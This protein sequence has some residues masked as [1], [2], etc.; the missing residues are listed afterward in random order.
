MDSKIETIFLMSNIIVYEAPQT[1]RINT[2]PAFGS[3]VL[4]GLYR[5]WYRIFHVTTVYANDN[6]F[7][8]EVTPNAEKL[9]IGWLER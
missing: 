4:R 7:D 6:R 3:K 5:I 9:F 2:N 1:K 8:R